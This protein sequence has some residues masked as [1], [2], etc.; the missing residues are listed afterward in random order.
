MN[1]YIENEY[2]REIDVDYTDIINKV[3]CQAVDFIK[4]PYECEVN[5]TIVDNN[6][7]HEINREQRKIDRPTDVLSFPMLDY[8]SITFDGKELTKTPAH[9]SNFNPDSGELILGDIVISY[10]KVI[11]Q[12]AEYNHS[13]NRELAFLVAHSMLHLFGFDHM[14]DDERIEMEEKQNIILNNLGITREN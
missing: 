11:E 7:I 1:I 4:C 6:T 8:E 10:D 2:D 9:I 13:R 14:V 5:V 3:V 12:A